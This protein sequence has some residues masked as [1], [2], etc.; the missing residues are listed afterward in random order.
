MGAGRAR[1]RTHARR[2]HRGEHGPAHG[3]P[4]PHVAFAAEIAELHTLTEEALRV[5]ELVDNPGNYLSLLGML[6]AFEGVEVWGDQLGNVIG[7]EFE[8]PC[9]DCETEN[10]I[11]FGRHGYFSTLDDMYMNSEAGNRIPLRPADPLS[12]DGLAERLHAR[13]GA[14]GYPDLADKLTYLFGSAECAECGTA[15]KVDEA[16]VARWG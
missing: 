10:F 5:P 4:D 8:L 13:I 15:F 1:Q 9:P 14:D 16:V 12:L 7:E 3:E 11:A 2:I 6:L